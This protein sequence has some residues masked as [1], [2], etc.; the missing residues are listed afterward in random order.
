MQVQEIVIGGLAPEE[1]RVIIEAMSVIG[2]PTEVFESLP[3]TSIIKDGQNALMVNPSILIYSD[4]LGGML[5]RFAVVPL[6]NLSY[7]IHEKR[8]MKI[9]VF[10]HSD[11]LGMALETAGSKTNL[12][13]QSMENPDYT[14][15]G[16]DQD[17]QAALLSVD[18]S[19]VYWDSNRLPLCLSASKGYHNFSPKSIN[20]ALGGD[21]NLLAQRIGG[22]PTERGLLTL[23]VEI[24]LSSPNSS[25]TP[26]D[27]R[28]TWSM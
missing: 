22:F 15:V 21:R 4:G 14:L 10:G 16:V 5:E 11:A 13:I 7:C 8:L 18:D 26:T 12:L 19:L 1:D 9:R 20:A 17:A 24:G 3:T 6:I 23:V 27:R 25:N 28:Q 2:T